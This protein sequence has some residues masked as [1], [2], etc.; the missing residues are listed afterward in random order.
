MT[1]DLEL[2]NFTDM[3]AKIDIDA[4]KFTNKRDRKLPKIKI[5]QPQLKIHWFL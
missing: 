4:L 1:E 2:N 5:G 3:V